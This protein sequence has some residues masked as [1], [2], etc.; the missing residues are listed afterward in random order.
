L[1]LAL[2]LGR[3]PDEL[4]DTIS[5]RHLEQYRRLYA[6]TAFGCEGDNW[7][8]AMVMSA[9]NGQSPQENLPKWEM[10]ND[11]EE[12]IDLGFANVCKIFKERRK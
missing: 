4:L 3:T 5:A 11:R 8:T 2:Q 9:M 10:G 1:I 12:F 6:E 7:R